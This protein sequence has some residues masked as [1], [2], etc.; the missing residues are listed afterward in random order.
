VTERANFEYLAGY[1]VGPLWSSYTRILAALVPADGNPTL[2]L[3]GFIAE[4][5]RAE[6]GWEVEAYDSL[7]RGAADL[8]AG[9]LETA[10]LRSGRIGLELG[11]ESRLAAPAGELE[12]LRGTLPGAAF[13][14]GTAALWA[15][16]A[17]K[18]RP[19]I[20]RLRIACRANAAGF[21]AGFGRAQAGASERTVA[22][23]M[24]A[25]GTTAGTALGA[26]VQPGWIGMT[27]G[28]AGYARF[29]GGPRDRA[30]EPGDMLWAD[31]G[32]T[33]DGYWSDYCRAAVVGGPSP[34][35]VDRQRRIA[36][37]T[38]AGV[39][40]CRPGVAIADIA[41]EVRRSS[42]RLGLAG[43]GFGRLG[44]GIGLN[45]T[46]PP[47]VVEHDRTVLGAGMVVTIEPAATYADGL[48]CAEQIVIVGDPP[49][50][51][52]TEPSELRSI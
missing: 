51:L 15:V 26:W 36:Q 21:A 50:L 29:V 8:M 11:R 49:E 24:L 3:P 34:Q 7:D 38:T 10:G 14:D 32:F 44:H 27:S 46:E 39:A 45:A 43:L 41:R 1:V 19:E 22:A 23:E 52:S 48:Y 47:S 5:A 25:A 37:A 16:R 18:S 2:L 33:A 42:E 31:L 20:E 28:A 35:Q 40:M 30:L 9:L 17:I 4:E 6:S 13:D 12:R